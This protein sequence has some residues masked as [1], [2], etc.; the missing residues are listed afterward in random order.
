MIPP[1]RGIEY[2][3]VGRDRT[4]DVEVMTALSRRACLGEIWFRF[5][6]FVLGPWRRRVA[7]VDG[8]LRR[9]GADPMTFDERV[10]V[11]AKNGFT[12]RQARFLMTVMLHPASASRAIRRFCRIVHGQKTRK[13]FATL[14]RLG[15]AS[16]YDC[17]HNRARSTT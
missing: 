17:R 2:H 9:R 4:L 6:S 7:A 15:Y 3:A 16:I 1:T 8:R 10:A 14:V 5:R 12:D 13:F 11:V